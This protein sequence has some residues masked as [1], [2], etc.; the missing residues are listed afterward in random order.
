MSN[1]DTLR[2]RLNSGEHLF[3]DTL[4]FIAQHYDYTPPA[5]CCGTHRP[6]PR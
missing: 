6:L 4:A 3:A 5:G 2:T 1:L